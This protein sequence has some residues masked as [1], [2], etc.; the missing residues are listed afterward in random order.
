MSLSAYLSFD[1]LLLHV[2]GVFRVLTRGAFR[3]HL[4]SS[5]NEL[6]EALSAAHRRAQPVVATGP[7]RHRE[8]GG[9]GTAGRRG[10]AGGH[11]ATGGGAARGVAKTPP[12]RGCA[13]TAEAA[14]AAEAALTAAAAELPGLA[15]P[16]LPPRN[17]AIAKGARP[18]IEDITPLSS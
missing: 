12:E 7:Q 1:F 2:L 4:E 9:R 16:A 18:L 6:A 8:S 13:G 5:R 17:R 15:G 11:T 3:H 10:A 14:K